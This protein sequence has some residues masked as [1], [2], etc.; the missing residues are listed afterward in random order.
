M[1][2]DIVL[3]GVLAISAVNAQAQDADTVVAEGVVDAPADYEMWTVMYLEPIGAM[4]TA[5]RVVSLG[6]GPDEEAQQMRMFFERGNAQTI[7]QLQHA[8]SAAAADDAPRGVEI[9]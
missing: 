2:R 4:R 6:F 7:E 8:L 5:V 1:I 9:R 3:I